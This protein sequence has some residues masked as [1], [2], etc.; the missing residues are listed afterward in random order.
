MAEDVWMLIQLCLAAGAAGMGVT[1]VLGLA[2]S[3]IFKKNIF[4]GELGK[5]LCV[6]FSIPFFLLWFDFFMKR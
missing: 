6:V 2:I 5:F 1:V 4:K 3:G